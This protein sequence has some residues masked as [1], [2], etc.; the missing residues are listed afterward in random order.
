MDCSF[1]G[2]LIT[3]AKTTQ[4][5]LLVV[6]VLA[7]PAATFSCF[8]D[9]SS[10]ARDKTQWDTVGFACCLR[11][12]LS[13]TI[14][15]TYMQGY[16][17]LETFWQK[18]NVFFVPFRVLQCLCHICTTRHVADKTKDLCPTEVAGAR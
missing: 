10:F 12:V 4:S 5:F 18:I 17:L 6:L 7:G 3:R 8:Q 1:T 15:S 11:A 13:Y 14:Y 2:F 16:G 9:G